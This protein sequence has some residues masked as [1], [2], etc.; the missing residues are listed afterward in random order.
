MVLF[1]MNVWLPDRLLMKVDKM[2]MASSVEARAPFMDHVLVEFAN[3]MPYKF[4]LDKYILKKALV[5]IL[6]K[7]TLNRKK[8]G[9]AVPI[10][11]WFKEDLYGF[12]ENLLDTHH[13]SRLFRKDVVKKILE[14]HRKV[15]NDHKL[16]NLINFE[17]WHKIYIENWKSGRRP[18]IKI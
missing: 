6:P 15:R 13:E 18:V 1:D 5:G 7:E 8:H 17:L 16:W 4:R 10:G 3:Q 2:T 12:A 9:F 11:D 14:N